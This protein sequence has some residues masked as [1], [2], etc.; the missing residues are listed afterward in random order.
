[1]FAVGQKWVQVVG[2]R[3]GC[4]VNRQSTSSLFAV[5]DSN[6]CHPSQEPAETR[7]LVPAP[8]QALVSRGEAV[9]FARDSF[10]KEDSAIGV[11]P[12]GTGLAG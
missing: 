11:V 10:R 4:T 8:R 7:T 5:P 9:H 1:M 2:S 3:A 6:R 12:L